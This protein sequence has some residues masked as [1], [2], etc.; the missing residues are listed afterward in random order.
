MSRKN[1]FFEKNKRI[2]GIDKEYKSCLLYTS[3]RT[4]QH[5]LSVSTND[6]MPFGTNIA[7]IL[8]AFCLI[9]IIY[10]GVQITFSL[11][12]RRVTGKRDITEVVNAE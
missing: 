2:P 3:A 10:W 11:G 8:T 12:I 7:V 1:I 9:H 6:Y 4:I 5:S